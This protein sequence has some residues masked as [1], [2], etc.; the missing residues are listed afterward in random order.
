MMFLKKTTFLDSSPLYPHAQPLKDAN[1]IFVILP[2]SLITLRS[3]I[4]TQLIPQKL[5]RAMIT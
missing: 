3:E 1:L 5:F 2:Q 4:I